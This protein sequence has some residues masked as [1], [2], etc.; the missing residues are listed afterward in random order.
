GFRTP[1]RRRLAG[2]PGWDAA[3]TRL[4]RAPC[5]SAICAWYKQIMRR[6]CAGDLDTTKRPNGHDHRDTRPVRRPGRERRT[7]GPV[8]WAA[9]RESTGPQSAGQVTMSASINGTRTVREGPVLRWGIAATG[10]IARTVGHVIAAEPDMMV[11]AVG[12]RSLDR[13]RALAAELG[14]RQAYGSYAE[15]VRDPDIDVVYVATPQSHHLEVAELAI[16]A[17]K[18]VLCEKPL[19]AT[20][21]DAEKMVALAR[22]A[23]VFLMEAMWMRFNPLI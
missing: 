23:G 7:A 15:L 5:L 13:A 6:S 3:V 1:G 2:S 21:A 8:R 12:S 17:G 14:A 10:G 16:A 20:L 9:G 18:A 19:A 22:E 11:T 4:L